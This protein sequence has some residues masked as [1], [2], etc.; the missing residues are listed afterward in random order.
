MNNL[1]G[2]EL[3][4]FGLLYRQTASDLSTVLEDRSSAHF[5]SYL[6]H[7]LGRCHNFLYAGH[8]T[9]GKGLLAFY[10]NEYPRLFRANL[11]LTSLA[12]ALF[13]AGT[14]AGWAVTMHDPGFAHRL[15]GPQ[16][17]DTID[18]RKMWTESVVSLKPVASS[19]ITTNNL[20]VAFVAFALGLTG[21]GTV[22]L[23]VF[24]GLMLGAV[25]AATEQ[26]G[27][28]L[29]LWS[30]VAAH[31]VLEIPAILIAG[32]AGLALARGLFFPGLLPRRDSVAEAGR[33]GVRLL[34]GS[35]PLLLI[36]GTI[37]GFFS[38]THVSPVFKFGLA[39][40]LFATLVLYLSSARASSDL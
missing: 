11:P 4:E 5:A 40:L 14:I 19:A 18:Q 31:G 35:V 22:W 13:L 16:M 33:R 21:I 24:N 6:N 12:A 27:M 28:A 8:R 3:Q 36:A 1:T 20:S 37:E 32:G 34:L 7:L 10:R 30:F 26:A 39:G 29:S 17:M 23:M 38:P 2:A 15:L 9:E 25:A